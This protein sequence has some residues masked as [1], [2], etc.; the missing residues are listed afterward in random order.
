[1]MSAKEVEVAKAME[2]LKTVQ[3]EGQKDAC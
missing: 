3:E 2:R 1:M